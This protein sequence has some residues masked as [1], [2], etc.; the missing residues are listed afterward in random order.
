MSSAITCVD[1]L[2]ALLLEQKAA[3]NAQGAVSAQRRRERI[4]RVGDM[5]VAH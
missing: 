3:F 4:Q 1:S 5:R 2:S